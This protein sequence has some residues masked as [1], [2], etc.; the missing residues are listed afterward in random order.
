MT[1]LIVSG[2]APR[3]VPRLRDC[4]GRE[5]NRGLEAAFS[6]VPPCGTALPAAERKMEEHGEKSGL[7]TLKKNSF[8]D[9]TKRECL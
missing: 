1:L 2:L 8:F 4:A 7:P 6:A 5:T 9:G 3:A